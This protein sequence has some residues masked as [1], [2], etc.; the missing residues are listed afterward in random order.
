MVRHTGIPVW[1]EDR[2]HAWLAVNARTPEAL[3]ERCAA[4]QRLMD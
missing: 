4:M 2:V 1:Q 3:E